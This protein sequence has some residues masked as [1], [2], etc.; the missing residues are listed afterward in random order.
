MLHATFSGAESRVIAQAKR[1]GSAVT[2]A[3]SAA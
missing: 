2:K 3:V 1:I